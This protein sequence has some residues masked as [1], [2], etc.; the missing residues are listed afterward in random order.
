MLIG[1]TPELR[2]LPADRSFAAAAGSAVSRAGDVEIPGGTDARTEA[3][4]RRAVGGA[5]V[6][7]L[8]VGF[9]YGS[10]V[11]DRPELSH[12]ELEFDVA[13]ELGVPRL[14]FL[15]TEDT[16][17]P[18]ELFLDHEHGARQQ[19]FRARLR[20]D[21]LVTASVSSPAEVEAAVLDALSGLPRAAPAGTV[22]NSL[23]GTAHGNVVMAGAVH[24]DI[25]LAHKPDRDIGIHV[26]GA[27]EPFEPVD[28]EYH[29][30]VEIARKTPDVHRL[31]L[32]AD[33]DGTPAAAWRLR[34]ADVV[35]DSD[36]TTVEVTLRF[37]G[38]PLGAGPRRLTLEARNPDDDRSWSSNGVIVDAPAD[39]GA[40]LDLEVPG[41]GIW[42]S[43]TYRV[44]VVIRNRGNTRLEGS[45]TKS[46]DHR[47]QPGFL[48]PEAVGLAPNTAF[49]VAPGGEVRHEVSLTVPRQRWFTTTWHVPLGVAVRRY[50]VTAAP[51]G[52][53]QRGMLADLRDL[54]QRLMAWGRVP[55][56]L[57]RGVLAASGAGIL[58]LGVTCGVT[59]SPDAPAP[60]PRTVMACDADTAAI[61]L[62]ELTADD[63]RDHGSYALATERARLPA[64]L[65]PY[66]VQA[67][68]LA[69]ACPSVKRVVRPEF[70]AVLWL[71][72]L[73]SAKAAEVCPVL[74]RQAGCGVALTY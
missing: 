11:P 53:E 18:A 49:T 66:R 24:G 21:G 60:L 6:H 71:G 20:D 25:N 47:D 39:P 10:P 59:A 40:E 73:P 34:P 72:P 54:L 74:G 51:P 29:L 41:K 65:G 7:V 45:L 48:P 28:G 64:V 1:H 23:G 56:T 50:D 8:L 43:G 2:R 57:K 58:A 69:Y 15:L 14:V 26:A 67:T 68:E 35:L 62:G 32:S 13:G 42:T 3:A 27:H 61:V 22:V 4:C 52:L 55:L 63:A 9:R 16:R 37:T 30:P 12:P 31:S 44:E 5:D 38:T 36:H 17:G 70:T 19:R 46:W 33:V